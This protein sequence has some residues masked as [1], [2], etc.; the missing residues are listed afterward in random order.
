[1]R[2]FLGGMDDGNAKEVT[3]QVCAI[4]TML[5]SFSKATSKGDRITFDEGG[6]FTQNKATGE[7]TPLTQSG[8]MY[9]LE[10]WVSRKSSSDAGF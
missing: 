9:Y 6:I 3:A 1:M 10:M 4:N 8:G 2:K 5:M 7:R